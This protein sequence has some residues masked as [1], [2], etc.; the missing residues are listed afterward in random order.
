MGGSKDKY[1]S[2]RQGSNEL[3]SS[4]LSLFVSVIIPVYNDAKRLKICLECLENQTYP[5]NSYEVIVIDNGSDEGE[6]IISVVAN[7]KQAIAAYE[8]LPGSYAARNKGITQA[9]GE[10]IAFTDADCTP[11]NNWIENGVKNLL[12][13]PECGLVAGKV[14]ILFQNPNRL[15]TAE[16]YQKIFNP[17]PQ[18]EFIEREKFGAT[19]NVFTFKSVID[20]VGNFDATLKSGGDVEWGRRVYAFGYKQIYAEDTCVA[21]LARY[22]IKQI[23]KKTIRIVGGHYNLQQR[24]ADSFIQSNKIFLR[25]LA[26]DL[27]PP[28]KVTTR[29]FLDR[30]L[31][32]VDQKIKVTLVLFFIRYIVVKEKLRLKLGGIPARE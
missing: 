11:A 18:Q 26:Y 27:I 28:L 9:K 31:K 24:L 15:T 3:E 22:S 29:I 1:M 8:S 17:M 13:T 4:I 20:K 6:N 19:A 23:Y 12:Q 25:N 30:R 14:E 16:L 21:H 7:F 5:K 10:V 2:D 32:G